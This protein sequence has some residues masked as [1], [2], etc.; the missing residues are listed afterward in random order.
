MRA[1]PEHRPQ[2]AH[3]HT[4]A[5]HHV[6]G[7]PPPL[8]IDADF[9]NENGQQADGDQATQQQLMLTSLSPMSLPSAVI[10]AICPLPAPTPALFTSP[11]LPA[12]LSPS[13]AA[14][15]LP[16][17]LSLHDAVRSERYHDVAFFLQHGADATG[18]E[19]EGSSGSVGKN[20]RAAL[21]VTD[22]VMRIAMR[23]GGREVSSSSCWPAILLILL[24]HGAPPALS[25]SLTAGMCGLPVACG[26]ELKWSICQARFSAI[27]QLALVHLQHRHKE[28]GAAL[29]AATAELLSHHQ[30][31]Q[32]ELVDAL[33]R[34]QLDEEQEGR[35]RNRQTAIALR[36]QSMAAQLSARERRR[37]HRREDELQLRAADI[38]AAY[39]ERS[40]KLSALLAEI[41]P[42]GSRGQEAEH[43]VGC[44]TAAAARHDFLVRPVD[45]AT[46]GGQC[47]SVEAGW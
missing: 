41:E 46:R 14:R 37:Q 8:H 35:E 11:P 28:Q 29:A 40:D 5:A 34:L 4:P 38:R 3:P 42:R 18:M 21:T 6:S 25:A 9:Q 23:V 47:V 15:Y 24:Q 20:G 19:E 16:S 39:A 7:R 22:E 1:L 43:G 30:H 27:I 45:A 32:T 13:S 10:D 12:P 31:I 26:G 36:Y 2:A 44:A 33:T 17:S